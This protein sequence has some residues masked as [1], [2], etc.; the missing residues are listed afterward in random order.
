QR[1]HVQFE[2][3]AGAQAFGEFGG[4]VAEQCGIEHGGL[5][6]GTVANYRFLSAAMP[7]V[8]RGCARIAA[9][10]GKTMPTRSHHPSDTDSEYVFLRMPRHALRI[11]GIAAGVGFLLF[12]LT[13]WAG[14]DDD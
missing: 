8:H 3:P 10:E 12:L 2:A 14:R 9:L 4:L 7:G 11:V 1:G 6:C 13:W 5:E